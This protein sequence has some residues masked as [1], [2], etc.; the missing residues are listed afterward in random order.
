VEVAVVGYLR[1]VQKD[2]SMD[3]RKQAMDSVVVV[4]QQ[5]QEPPRKYTS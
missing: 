3:V 2:Y 1:V 4:E 5:E